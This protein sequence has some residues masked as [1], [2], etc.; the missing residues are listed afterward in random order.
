LEDL[1]A[2]LSRHE[3]HEVAQLALEQARDRLWVPSDVVP[4]HELELRNLYQLPETDHET[5]WVRSTGLQAFQEDGADLLVDAVAISLSVNVQDDAGEVEGVRV[6]VPKL[7]D[8]R[9]EEAEARLVVEGLHDL[10]EDVTGFPVLV[11]LVL[12]AALVGLPVG[13]EEDDGADHVRVD[14]PPSIHCFFALLHLVANISD[15]LRVPRPRVVFEVLPQVHQ[16]EVVA[17]VGQDPGALLDL[18]EQVDL[19]VLAERI[20]LLDLRWVSGQDEVAHLDAVLGQA[21]HEVEMEF[22]QEVGEVLLY[23]V[24]NAESA[25]VEGLDGWWHGLAWYHVVLEEA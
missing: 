10:L 18:G 24:E 17:V 25:V 12:G 16:G 23:H 4:P 15:Q 5:P 19:E 11:A 7:V 9:V 3:V 20:W 6:G 13:D 8:D 2:K 14:P 22:T 1:A 21:V